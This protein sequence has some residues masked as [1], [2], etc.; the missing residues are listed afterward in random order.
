MTMREY[1]VF[2]VALFTLLSV[3]AEESECEHINPNRK[4][5]EWDSLDRSECN[6]TEHK[7]NNEHKHYKYYEEGVNSY[8]F[9]VLTSDKIGPKRNVPKT[10]HELCEKVDYSD[11]SK[12][13]SI[14]I[15]Y[16]NE[17]LSVLVR[18]INGIFDRT[19]ENL[20]QEIILF[21]DYSESHLSIEESLKEYAEFHKWSKVK[22]LAATE[23][24]GLIRAKTL[25]AREATGDVV[26]VLDSHCEVNERWLEPLLKVIQE[27][28][29]TIVAPIV[30]LINPQNFVYEQSMVAK[31]GFD[32]AL[33]F[34]WEYFDWSYFDTEDHNVMPFESPA[35]SGGLMAIDRE[36]FKEIGEFDMGMEI[37]GGENIEISIRTWLCGGK[38]KIAPCSRVG[39]VFRMRRPYKSKPGV[40]TNALN[41][42]RIAKVWLGDHEKDYFK[43]RRS[44]ARLDAGDLS[45]RLSIKQ[46]LDCKP[47]SWFVENVYPALKP[48]HDEL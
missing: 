8:S 26:V 38:I 14:I 35:L 44:A 15:I 27:D 29:K 2:I 5:K 46:K 34:K 12:T 10:F 6:V 31:G 28:R 33:N 36:Y 48:K 47:F 43:V 7:L 17:A 37:W 41:T 30:D 25:A 19:P 45:E 20:L 11:V 42:L 3:K 18:M 39:H 21:D 23:R 13:A 40:D 1:T 4:L 9:N 32:W 24:Q 16:H 22:F